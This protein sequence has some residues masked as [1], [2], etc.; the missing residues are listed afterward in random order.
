MSRW[1][2]ARFCSLAA[3]LCLASALLHGASP[4]GNF[5]QANSG[6]CTISGWAR[7]P[8]TVN[9]INV[10][11]LRD[12]AE[13]TGV[14]VAQFQAN[15][16]RTDLPFT[17][18][19]HGFAYTPPLGDQLY[20]NNSHSIYIYAL[21]SGSDPN[22]FLG[23]KSIK[24]NYGAV[25]VYSPQTQVI[26]GQQVPLY[27]ETRDYQGGARDGTDPI[28]WTTSDANTVAVDS[29]GQITAKKMG[30]ATIT[31]TWL[32]FR[33]T[34][35][36]Q[37]IPL[38][39]DI[40]PPQINVNVGD[41][42][43]FTAV[44]RDI[45]QNAMPDPG[46]QWVVTGATGFNT[47]AASISGSGLFRAIAEGVITVRAQFNYSVGNSDLIQQYIQY[48]TVNIRVRKDY[49]LTRLASTL[50]QRDSFHL[51]PN[52][53]TIAANDNGQIAFVATLD[54]LT[55]ALTMYDGGN[56]RVLATS[57]VPGPLAGGVIRD[58][59]DVSINNNSDVL[60]RAGIWGTSWGLMMVQRDG[61]TSFP[62]LE[63]STAGGGSRFG[64]V[65]INRNSLGD[66]GDILFQAN[67]YWLVGPTDQQRGLM[68]ISKGSV[69]IVVSSSD[70][71]PGLSGP[72]S[73][74]NN[75]GLA[76]PGLVFFQAY[77]GSS[78][79]VYR[80]DYYGAISK[81]LAIGDPFQGS[82]V[83]GLGSLAMSRAGDLAFAVYLK[84]GTTWIAY[85]PGGNTS[86][87]PQTHQANWM[88]HVEAVSKAGVLWIGDDGCGGGLCM[89]KNSSGTAT[90]SALSIFNRL[91]PN[92]EPV[93][94]F[95][96]AFMNPGGDAYVQLRT[97]ANSFVVGKY[98]GGPSLMFKG[99]QPFNQ[100]LNLGFFG[101]VV[102]SHSVPPTVG[103]GNEY[104]FFDI[105]TGQLLPR[106]VTGD[107]PAGGAV[108]LGAYNYGHNPAGDLFFNGEDAIYRLPAAGGATQSVLKFPA[109]VDATTTV[110]YTNARVVAND[111][112]Q[113]VSVLGTNVGGHYRMVLI[114]GTTLTTIAQFGS[115]S[116]RRTTSPAGGYFSNWNGD[117]ALDNN[118]RVMANISVT[119]GPSGYFLYSGGTWT[120]TAL[121]NQFQVNGYTVSG[122]NGLKTSGADFYAILNLLGSTSA[123]C[124]WDGAAW[125][126]VVKRGDISPNGNGVNDFF[127]FD[128]NR[129]GDLVWVGNIQGVTAVLFRSA[130]GT[131]RAVY[132]NNKPTDAG[133]IF[134]DSFLD[135]SLLDDRRVYFTGLDAYGTL[136]L[137]VANPVF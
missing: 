130:D 100:V 33:A 41:T 19:N 117:F 38:R 14:L 71:L 85:Y 113:S 98:K 97:Q 74:D 48:A 108:F 53:R 84:D 6:N 55:E 49:Q 29:K 5:D 105:S 20:D 102:G 8:D 27:A 110:N 54:G 91:G 131:M 18:K 128:V 17:D 65:N 133:D 83:T 60:T 89:F 81:I 127:Q 45:N 67:F 1:S 7:D 22:T 125:T 28:T 120:A 3:V 63:G 62:F 23:T 47:Q 35:T 58:F 69:S 32:S 46:F 42:V 52:H 101:L 70:T 31:A 79:G 124:R 34:L 25:F 136:V 94:Q 24:C 76:G 57:G 51:R 39:V 106:F 4:T 95:N 115:T 118:G 61:T 107:Q 122:L 92:D 10:R 73:F 72:P 44:P 59:F 135:L 88:D 64:N 112:G 121:I 129:N 103:T 90:S 82:T 50:D 93:T 78:R 104:S 132:L 43:Q 80:S 16:L 21:D 119:G 75:Y 40:T 26:I 36:I 87:A 111:K 68:A 77:S 11:I 56:M 15:L 137:Y 86:V 13:G 126:P 66:N 134:S 2:I 37:V 96:A 123:L 9:P 12:G 109:A 99:G 30:L 114:D 116:D